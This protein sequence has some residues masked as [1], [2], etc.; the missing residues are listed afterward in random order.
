M[1]HVCVYCTDG[2]VTTACSYLK[3]KLPA[4]QVISQDIEHPYHLGKDENSVASLLQ[5]HQQFVQQNELP[6]ATDQ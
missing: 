4:P 2:H 3:E 5:A 6:T 1:R